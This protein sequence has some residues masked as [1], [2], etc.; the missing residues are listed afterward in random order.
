MSVVCFG[1]LL[2]D[3][4]P[5][6]KGV[7]VGD[8]AQFIKAAGGAPAN[9][10]VALS[11]LNHTAAFLGQ[12]GDDP[13]GHFLAKT[14]Q[15][16]GVNIE[17]L[18]FSQ[19]ALTALAFVELSDSADRS[20]IFYRKPS[21]D[22]LMRPEDVAFDLIQG[23]RVFHFGSITLIS[24]PS[25]SATLAAVEYARDNGLLIS[26]DPN[27]R[28]NLWPD[29][30]AAHAGLMIGF[31]YA[32][33]VKV[34]AEE[35]EFLTGGSDAM[36]LFRPQTLILAVTHGAEGATLY[37]REQEIFMPAFAV[38]AVDTTGA[39]DAFMAALISGVL[40]A[41]ESLADQLAEI[42]RFACAAGAIT[43]MTKGAIPALPTRHQL[44][45]FLD[46]Y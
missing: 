12:V 44:Y 29:R 18:R 21:A 6:E 9:V 40:E 1:E 11:R 23:R 42:G 31:D 3:F 30:E 43:T 32:Q 37:T 7:T 36:A 15:E 35:L 46:N 5:T 28:M 17:G 34:S 14:L 16:A 2:I 39:G 45:E 19:E 13:F 41:G 27:L 25:R 26:Y 38:N 24:E 20:F 22:M 8:A 33:I 4:V 10:A